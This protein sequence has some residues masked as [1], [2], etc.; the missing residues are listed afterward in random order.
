MM[1]GNWRPFPG[2]LER[3]TDWLLAGTELCAG[4][5]QTTANP[6]TAQNP[7]KRLCQKEAIFKNQV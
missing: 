6:A 4:A 3:S 5:E 2:G 7:H 1:P